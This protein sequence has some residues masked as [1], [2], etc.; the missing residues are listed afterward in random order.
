[1]SAETHPLKPFLPP[2]SKI[3]MLGSFP[4]PQARWCMNFYYPNFNNDMWR[5]L[6]KAFFDDRE[7]F[8]CQNVRVFDKEKIV[9][10][11]N[12][13]GIAI[14]DVAEKVDR[15]R[16]N[17]SDAFLK[18]VQT[19]DVMGILKKLPKCIAV[20][21]TGT[22]ATETLS[23]LLETATPPVGGKSPFWI[24]DRQLHLYRTPSSSRAYPL[25]FEKKVAA[26]QKLFSEIGLR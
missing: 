8:I 2:S 4:P 20:N 3:L 25:P 19:T 22:L 15:L 17:A 9:K 18:I 14:Y 26:Y 16:G 23:R 11:L 5:I 21:T 13:T 1:M 7:Y 6:G 12:E 24:G 10:F